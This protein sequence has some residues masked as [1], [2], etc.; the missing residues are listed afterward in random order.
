[1][2]TCDGNL[3]GT[4]VVLPKGNTFAVTVC[5]ERLSYYV[6]KIKSR[7]TRSEEPSVVGGIKALAL[8]EGV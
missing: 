8:G 5:D 2:K 3:L 6:A 1:M 4:L 7:F